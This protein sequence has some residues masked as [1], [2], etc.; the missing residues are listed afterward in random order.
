MFK[1]FL[2]PTLLLI[3]TTSAFAQSQTAPATPVKTQSAP[4]L[5]PQQKA[6]LENQNMHMAQAAQQIAQMV[7]RNRSGAVWDG[8]SSV[9]KQ[10]N[11]RADF[12]QKTSAD[13][14]RLGAFSSRKLMAV[15]RTFSKGGK[16]PAGVYINVNYATQFAN[17]RQPIRELISFHL[18]N[19][20]T[21]RVAG[22]TVH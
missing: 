9:A 2:L 13:R 16:L 21:W 10:T 6:Q 11:S 18:D 22:Y 8:A 1:K 3:A 15:T 14:A 20:K 7:D 4:T 5:T 19:D 17:S 12:I